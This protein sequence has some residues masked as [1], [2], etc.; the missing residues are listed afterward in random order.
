MR[1]CHRR[2]AAG[3]VAVLGLGALAPSVLAAN[4]EHE[5]LMADLRMLQ[6]QTQ[7]LQVALNALSEALK[8]LTTRLDDQGA[9]SRKAFADQKVQIDTLGSDMRVV[10]EKLDETNVRLS[11]LSQ[12]MEAMRLSAVPPAPPTA[13][14]PVEPGTSPTTTEPQAAAPPP[15]PAPATAGLSPQRLYDTAY[16]DFASGQWTLAIQGFETYIRTFPRTEQADDAQ[17]YIGESYSLDGKFAE[18]VAAY[19]KVIANYPTADATPLAYYK[20]GLALVR[21]GQPDRARESWQTVIQKFPDSDASR[22]AKQGID[23][24]TR[25]NR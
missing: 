16:A 24:L 8:L 6:E 25:S 10:R 7:Q 13:D 23:R 5:V 22:L 19:D 4:R 9:A 1:R 15:A 3:I 12:E 20:R 17:L 18:A 14:L 11:S 21:L 2:L